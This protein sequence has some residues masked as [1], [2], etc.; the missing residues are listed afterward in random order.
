[1]ESTNPRPHGRRTLRTLAWAATF[2]AFPVGGLVTMC[3]VGAV[4]DVASAAIGGTL[5]GALVGLAQS[6]GS[7]AVD[8]ARVLPMAR[9]IPATA[10]GM[11]AGLAAGASVVAFDTSLASLAAMGAITGV[12]LGAAQAAALPRT[13]APS[14]LP[15]LAWA[16]ATPAILSA[17]WIV[18]TAAGVDVEQQYAV[19]GATG[20]LVATGLVGVTLWALARHARIRAAA[21]AA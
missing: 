10:L 6:L 11:G 13:L 9:W 16:A 19:F 20:A 21:V 4:D 12:V 2:I 3:T 7:R 18:T 17:G 1:M 8:R 15:R 5:V 14:L